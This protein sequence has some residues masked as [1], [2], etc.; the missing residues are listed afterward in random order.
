VF[1][2]VRGRDRDKI[3]DS[4]ERVRGRGGRCMRERAER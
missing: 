4:R 3:R 1:G 2:C